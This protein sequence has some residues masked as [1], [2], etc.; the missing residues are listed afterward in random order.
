[1]HK[2]WKKTKEGHQ[3]GHLTTLEESDVTFHVSLTGWDPVHQSEV[4]ASH[5]YSMSDVF[6]NCRFGDMFVTDQTTQKVECSLNN[7]NKVVL[8]DVESSDNVV[9][10]MGEV[11][12]E[13][14]LQSWLEEQEGRQEGGQEVGQVGTQEE[15]EE[16]GY[17][18][19][20]LEMK[21]SASGTTGTTT[22]TTT[23]SKPS[24]DFTAGMAKNF[25]S[26]TTKF[27]STGKFSGLSLSCSH[28]LCCCC[29]HHCCPDHSVLCGC[30]GCCVDSRAILFRPLGINAAASV[31]ITG[32]NK[33]FEFYHGSTWFWYVLRW[34]LFA[35]AGLI[36]L[37]YTVLC[38]SMALPLYITNVV[39]HTNLIQDVSLTTGIIIENVTQSPSYKNSFF[40][41][42]QTISSIGYGVLSPRSDASNWFVAFF[43]FLGFIVLSM[44]SG[45]IWSKFTT[46]NGAL[47]AI[48]NVIVIT[49]FQGKRALMFRMAGLWRHHPISTATVTAMVYIPHKNDA[50]GQVRVVAKP[51]K[52][53]RSYNPLFLLPGTFVHIMEDD[54]SPLRDLTRKELLKKDSN[55][56]G[57]NQLW[58]ALVFE[59]VDTCRGETVAG[60]YRFTH[61]NMLW[62]QRFEDILRFDTVDDLIHV[63]M[64]KFHLTLPDG[65]KEEDDEEIKVEEIKVE[66]DEIVVV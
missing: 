40:F 54:D 38:T 61:K 6:F 16:D 32:H 19:P 55:R 10:W 1:M 14:F 44:L 24:K 52:L 18:N 45:V 36:L 5:F 28:M 48:S 37:L 7:I 43:G 13:R 46:S 29:R 27:K 34:S 49:K 15:H 57:S 2:L 9:Q 66:E 63:D 51:L 39:T 22:G 62:G 23:T 35:F 25:R 58:I 11:S 42:H 17:T 26:I 50:D 33:V 21:E 41:S 47:V 64:N 20:M 3:T 12:S 4:H 56:L 65:I 8:Q 31:Q 60:Q 53:V 30:C 59:G